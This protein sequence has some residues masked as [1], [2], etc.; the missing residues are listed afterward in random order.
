MIAYENLKFRYEPFPIGVARPAFHQER[1]EELANKFPPL[2]LFCFKPGLGNKYSLS[3]KDGGTN[4]RDF[5]NK[6]KCWSKLYEWIKSETFIPDV[7]RA[8]RNCHIDL[9]RKR[10]TGLSAR[11]EFSMLPAD[12]GYILPHTDG[13]AKIVTLVVSMAQEGEWEPTFGGGTDINR[14][15]D[16]RHAFNWLNGQAEFDDMEV[17]DTVQYQPNQAV[18]F[19]KTF[20]S[21]HSVRPMTGTGSSLMRKTL[22]INIE[23]DVKE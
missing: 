3:E 2:D 18:V 4:Y 7:M 17:L 11:F 15:K 22:T 1:Y 5:I 8:L 6:H 9:G 10:G 19:I 12:G 20:N 21:W 14:A 23:S 13:R 16:I